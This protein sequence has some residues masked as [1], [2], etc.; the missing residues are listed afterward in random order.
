MLSMLTGW[1]RARSSDTRAAAV[2]DWLNW[3]ESNRLTITGEDAQGAVVGEKCEEPMGAIHDR[4]V[5]GFVQA[6]H[7]AIDERVPLVADERAVFNFQV[8]QAIYRSAE[9]GTPQMVR[10]NH[11]HQR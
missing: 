7:G 6:I 11:S 5:Q 4:P 10:L 2:Y 9:L 1:A 3:G 8:I